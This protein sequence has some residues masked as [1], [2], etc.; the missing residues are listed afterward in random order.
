MKSLSLFWDSRVVL[1]L[2]RLSWSTT[3]GCRVEALRTPGEEFAY[4][5]MT[6]A[7]CETDEAFTIAVTKM[8][9]T[10]DETAARPSL[11]ARWKTQGLVLP[12]RLRCQ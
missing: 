3:G 4:I 11:A 1:Y 9:G 6:L 7:A 2:Q 8:D 5:G 10:R 12:I